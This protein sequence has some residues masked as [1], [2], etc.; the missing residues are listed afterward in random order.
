M[1]WTRRKC[2]PGRT[3]CGAASTKQ[4]GVRF[5]ALVDQPRLRR[6][7]TPPARAFEIMEF[8]TPR[9]LNGARRRIIADPGIKIVTALWATYGR[10]ILRPVR[11]VTTR[12]L[13]VPPARSADPQAVPRTGRATAASTPPTS[14]R[15]EASG[16]SCLSGR[17]SGHGT[18]RTGLRVPSRIRVT[19]RRGTTAGTAHS[20]RDP[21]RHEQRTPSTR[22]SPRTY[23]CGRPQPRLL[24]AMPRGRCPRQVSVLTPG[25]SFTP[26]FQP[27]GHGPPCSPVTVA[28]PAG[29]S[30][31][32]WF[33]SRSSAATVANQPPTGRSVKSTIRCWA[34][35]MR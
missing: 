33:P 11:S 29:C 18:A 17:F 19:G 34:A 32:S 28:G 13:P 12:L 10:S 24:A 31:A 27:C 25:L 14:R 23:R 2:R 3:V 7:G 30:P 35:L 15:H 21:L 16:R 22:T 20:G 26:T 4:R 6:P 5:T 8:S 9:D 1:T